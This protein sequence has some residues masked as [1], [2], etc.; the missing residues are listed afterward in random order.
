MKK[1]EHLW[2]LE[3]ISRSFLGV[4]AIFCVLNWPPQ[5]HTSDAVSIYKPTMSI[6]A[7]SLSLFLVSTSAPFYPACSTL[8][9]EPLMRAF[10]IRSKFSVPGPHLFPRFFIISLWFFFF[11][12]L[13]SRMPPVPINKPAVHCLGFQF[14]KTEKPRRETS[15][16]ILEHL[17][18]QAL[19]NTWR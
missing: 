7:L 11:F 12:Y 6:I 8:I 10:R 15:W 3:D 18:L 14:S 17:G 16:E 5:R 4:E 2:R 9:L 13:L 1:K 19:C